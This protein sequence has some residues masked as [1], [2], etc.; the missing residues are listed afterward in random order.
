MLKVMDLYLCGRRMQ[1]GNGKLTSFWCDARCGHN[2]LKDTFPDI[3]V[4]A[5]NKI[6]Q[7]LVLLLWAGT[8]LWEDIYLMISLFKHMVSLVSW[9]KLFSRL[10]KRQTFLEM[11]K[12]WN[13]LY[14]IN[15]QPSL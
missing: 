13:L 12:K 9:G 1:D 8:S 2:P 14:E 5:M 7:F 11:D 10:G 6:L 4:F 15:V 3:S